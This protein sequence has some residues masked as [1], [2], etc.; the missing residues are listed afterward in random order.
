MFG[1]IRVKWLV[2]GCKGQSKSVVP[3]CW[4]VATRWVEVAA[5]SAVIYVGWAE[6]FLAAS[7]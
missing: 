6:W 4:V 1:D 5:Q 7:H 3:L 2:L